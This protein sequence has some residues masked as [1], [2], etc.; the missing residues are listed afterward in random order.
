MDINT[1]TQNQV[2]NPA[3]NGRLTSVQRGNP[4]WRNISFYIRS[5]IQYAILFII[6]YTVLKYLLCL[7]LGIQAVQ[8]TLN[9]P[10]YAMAIM[11]IAIFEYYCLYEFCPGLCM[12]R[13]IHR[14][15]NIKRIQLFCHRLEEVSNA[16]F[17]SWEQFQMRIEQ[18]FDYTDYK[19]ASSIL[20]W[21]LSHSS[22]SWKQKLEFYD[23]GLVIHM[24][25][26]LKHIYLPLFYTLLNQTSWVT[27][28]EA[29]QSYMRPILEAYLRYYIDGMFNYYSGFAF[30]A[31][32]EPYASG[33]YKH[34]Q[35]AQMCTFFAGSTLTSQMI[36]KWIQYIQDSSH[37]PLPTRILYKD[38]ELQQAR[39]VAGMHSEQD[40]YQASDIAHIDKK[41]IIIPLIFVVCMLLL[42]ILKHFFPIIQFYWQCRQ[43]MGT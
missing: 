1:I 33:Y 31:D 25:H 19:D 43:A 3:Q 23:H 26:A 22:A 12:M 29:Q 38:E 35:D 9:P 28:P 24:I 36:E 17:T 42:A 30:G 4:I 6:T 34:A 10:I 13:A 2:N 40:F 27:I 21:S 39:D 5:I 37:T 20:R 11:W 7:D 8:Q 16:Q 41:P 18:L 15:S 32:G 14:R